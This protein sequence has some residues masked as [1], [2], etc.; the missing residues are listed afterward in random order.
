MHCAHYAASNPA[1]Y[2]Q[3]MRINIMRPI[4]PH[5]MR[6][7]AHKHYAHNAAKFAC[8]VPFSNKFAS[9][10]RHNFSHAYYAKVDEACFT[11]IQ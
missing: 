10:L 8:C 6:I 1:F 7:M 3:I 11:Y 4:M 9:S 2:A 5:I